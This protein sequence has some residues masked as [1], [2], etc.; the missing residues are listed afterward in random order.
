M[1]NSTHLNRLIVVST[2]FSL[3]LFIL[4]W[5]M[6]DLTVLHRQFLQGQGNAR[7]LRV[8]DIPAHR[9]MI[10]DR[11]G[12]PLAISTP[13][14]SVWV[15]PK[16][17]APDKEQF[18]SF[19][20]YLNL[21]PQQL[22]R[23]IV[24][25]ENK[26]L[27]FL[28]LQRQLPPPLA[29]KIKAL[30][31]PG[32]N[33]QKEFKR[34]YPDSDS[35]SQ[36]VGFTNVDDQGLEGIELAYQDWLKGVVGKKRVIKDRLGRVI[37]ELGV[38]K[39]PRPGRDMTLSIDRRLQYLA[40][41]ELTKTVEE[42]AAKSGSVVVI[43]TEN[44]E[45]LAMANVPSYNPNSR[46]R[47][48]KDSY[49]NRAVTDMFEPGSVIK[50]FSIASALETGLFT[51]STI[52]DTNPSWM[53]VQGRIVRDIHNYG[54]LDVTGVLQHSSNVGVTKMVLASPPEQLIGLLQRCGFGQRTES[55]CPGE[56]EGSIVNIK[57]AKP[58]VLA[59]VSFGYGLS[60]TALQLAKANMVFANL[61]KL[62]PV[63]LLHNDPPTPGVQVMKPETAQQVLSM[64][65]AVLGK[66]GTGKAARVPGYRVAGKTGTARIAGKDGYKDRKYT[67]SFIG[68]APVSKPKF[69]V[70][71]IIHEPSRKG[72][73][74]AAVAAPL[75]AK[76]MSGALRLFN[77]P[78]DELTG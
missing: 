11:N 60:V 3:L 15:N 46:G 7:S 50:T 27:E 61:G 62:I 24:D 64:M 29:K 32:V 74:A 73:Y 33:F 10:M 59:T 18:M 52:I 30:K 37:E 49:R 65:E 14:E 70:V 6:V 9:G 31:I 69:V 78:T 66:D 2:F 1:K 63:T 25:A 23:K 58:F 76:V 17:F 47:Y 51:P 75:F 12:T 40:Y 77:I 72:Y 28:Y 34:Y 35:I 68:I 22:S 53:N 13:V 39:Q 41:S 36:L 8:V 45:I 54:V 55:T 20:E 38:I 4:I 26:E 16:E 57:D 43:D 5:R 56:S 42:F 19:A 67:A 44:G 71:V 21:T 48:D